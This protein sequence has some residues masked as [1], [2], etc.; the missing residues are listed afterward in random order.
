[1]GA[2]QSIVKMLRVLLSGNAH[3]S[4]LRRRSKGSIR[5]RRTIAATARGYHGQ[6]A[7]VGGGAAGATA[8]RCPAELSGDTER[9]VAPTGGQ[10]TREHPGRSLSE[11]PESLGRERHSPASSR[12]SFFCLGNGAPSL[13]RC[14]HWLRG[15]RALACLVRAVG[16]AQQPAKKTLRVT[17]AGER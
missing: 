15:E 5:S 13:C 16:E 8:R 9:A 4:S 6:T 1:M 17:E 10:A 7:A 11:M 3:P 2:L 14:R 12:G